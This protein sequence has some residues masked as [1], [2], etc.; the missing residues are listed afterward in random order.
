MVY[1]FSGRNSNRQQQSDLS[2][3]DWAGAERAAVMAPTQTSMQLAV[4]SEAL[5]LPV[6][7]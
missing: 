1:L 2:Q 5:E 3:I 6:P 4:G 7:V